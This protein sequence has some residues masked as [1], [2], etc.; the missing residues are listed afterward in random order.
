[1]S[2]RFKVEKMFQFLTSYLIIIFNE[3]VE[4]YKKNYNNK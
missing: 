2:T 3:N 4:H 1:M